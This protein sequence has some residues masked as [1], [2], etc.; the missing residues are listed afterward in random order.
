MYQKLASITTVETYWVPGHEGVEGNE[1]VDRLAK[2]GAALP[3]D[4]TQK[5][6]LIDT[7]PSSRNEER[8]R[9]F[10]MVPSKAQPQGLYYLL[11]QTAQNTGTYRPL[12]QDHSSPSLV[13]GLQAC[14]EVST[15]VLAA[16]NFKPKR[17]GKFF[18]SRV[19]A[20]CCRAQ[21][22]ALRDAGW[23]MRDVRSREPA[24]VPKM[25]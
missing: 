5:P 4:A 11:M 19:L 24:S 23:G 18:I 1:E 7:P 8:P 20:Y 2:E 17:L 15:R 22:G 16:P 9:R 13:A 25:G 12:P 14:P 21:R 6:T 10:C 3:A